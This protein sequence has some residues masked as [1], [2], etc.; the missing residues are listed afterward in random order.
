[1]SLDL[2]LFT[3]SASRYASKFLRLEH[4]IA[5]LSFWFVVFFIGF[6]CVE[7]KNKI[8]KRFVNKFIKIIR[9]SSTQRGK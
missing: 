8:K 3:V 2:P 5:R 7:P 1:M 4:L 6:S 9:R